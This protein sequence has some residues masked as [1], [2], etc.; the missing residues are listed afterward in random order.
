MLKI[1]LDSEDPGRGLHGQGVAVCFFPFAS[2][3]PWRSGVLLPGTRIGT[4]YVISCADSISEGRGGGDRAGDTLHRAGQD[5]GR[6]WL[7]LGRRVST[8]S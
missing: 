1:M 7:S 4:G 6:Q 8:L 5:G 3:T 2:A